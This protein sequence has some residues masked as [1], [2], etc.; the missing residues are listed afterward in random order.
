MDDS[1][2]VHHATKIMLQDR[3]ACASQ[4]EIVDRMQ[5]HLGKSDVGVI[6]LRRLFQ[7][8]LKDASE[9]RAPRGVLRQTPDMLRFD[10]V[11]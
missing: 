10:N 4:G 1:D 2:P 8:A 3:F 7:E 9:G 6:A 11:C 5:E